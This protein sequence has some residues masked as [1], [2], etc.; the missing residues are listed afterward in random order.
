MQWAN[1][2]VSLMQG[3]G[4]EMD[5]FGDSNGI[6]DLNASRAVSSATGVV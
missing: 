1:A 3:L 6:L 2:F 4:H 5:S